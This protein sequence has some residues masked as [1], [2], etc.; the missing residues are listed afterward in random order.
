[1]QFLRFLPAAFAIIVWA[2]APNPP[3]GVGNFH[4]VNDHIYRGAQPT[5]DGVQS[6]AKLGVHTVIDLRGGKEHSAEEE[7][8]VKAAGMHYVHVPMKGLEAPTD[9]QIA[10]ILALLDDSSGWPVFVHCRRGA[11]RTGTVI[12]CYRI[13][14]DHWDNVRA[15]H[16]ARLDGMSWIERAME[17]YVLSFKPPASDSVAS[18][19]VAGQ[20]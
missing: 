6:L 3:A 2:G 1:M 13:A 20:P 19:H 5:P 15:L 12:A 11:D 14:H 8:L 4:A 7:R 16:E 9:Q 17:R 18:A 10:T